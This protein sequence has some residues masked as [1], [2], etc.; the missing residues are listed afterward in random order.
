MFAVEWKLLERF[1]PRKFDLDEARERFEG[2]RTST[3]SST[4][5]TSCA[6]SIDAWPGWRLIQRHASSICP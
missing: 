4:P 3:S 6:R 5:T 2:R 1:E